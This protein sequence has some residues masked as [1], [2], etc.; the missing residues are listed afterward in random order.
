MK[1]C[2]YCNIIK[3]LSEF[4]KKKTGK[5]GVKAECKS[6]SIIYEKI[7]WQKDKHKQ[8]SEEKIQYRKEYYSK[9]KEKILQRSKEWAKNNLHKKRLY[10]SNRRAILLKA[11]SLWSDKDF[12]KEIYKQASFM[13]N[14]YGIKYEVDHIIPL[15]GKFVCGLHNQFNLQIISITENRSKAAKYKG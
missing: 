8:Q 15:Q 12:I 10:R 13:S 11:N 14:K 7:R 5:F 4:Y 3:P 9:N 6:C 2:K 1:H